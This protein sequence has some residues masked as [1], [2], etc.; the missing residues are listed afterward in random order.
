MGTAL[1]DVRALPENWKR[2]ARGGSYSLQP[3]DR[4]FDSMRSEFPSIW[5][6]LI[7]LAMYSFKAVVLAQE[8]IPRISSTLVLNSITSSKACSAVSPNVTN[9]M[10]MKLAMYKINPSRKT[11][12]LVHS[13]ASSSATN[14]IKNGTREVH[15]SGIVITV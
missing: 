7:N 5:C 11:Q 10:A 3:F 1:P 12:W 6:S 2:E 4:S 14:H 8:S 13:P 9:R 15:R